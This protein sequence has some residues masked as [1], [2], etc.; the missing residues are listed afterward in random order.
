MTLI[1]F[2]VISALNPALLKNISGMRKCRGF[3][4]ERFLEKTRPVIEALKEIG[5]KHAASPAQVA[6]N[7]LFSAPGETVVVIPGATKTAQAASN[8][9]AM[10]SALSADEI[11]HLDRVSRPWRRDSRRT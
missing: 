7:W 1:C 4:K 11:D 10:A 3:Y 6:L 5:T 9:G 2:A 8:A